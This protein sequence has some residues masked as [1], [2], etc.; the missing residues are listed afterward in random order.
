MALI[1]SDEHTVLVADDSDDIRDL[2]RM[3]LEMR[4]CHVVEA[5]NGAVAVALADSTR[6]ALILMDLSMPILD[7]YEATRQIHERPL[8]QETPIVAVSAF[9]DTHNRSKALAAGCIECVCK[10][11][12]FGQLDGLLKKHLRA[13]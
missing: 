8:L 6:P 1:T 2:L 10:P 9:C 3:M 4:G 11:M 12:D 13:H 7:G 5:A